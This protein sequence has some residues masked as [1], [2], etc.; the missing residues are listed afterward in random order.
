MTVKAYEAIARALVDSGQQQMFGILGDAN[1]AYCAKFMDLGGHFVGS[2]HEGNALSMADGHT[3]ESDSV[4]VVSVTCGPAV[5]NTI[6]A[7]TEA[8]RVG[9]PILLLTGDIPPIRDF[10]Q[11]IDLPTVAALTGAEFRR[12]LLAEH[13]VDDIAR[14]LNHVAASRVPMILDIPYSLLNQEVD[15]ERPGFKTLEPATPV[16]DADQLDRAVGI[17]A[18]ARRPV[19]L[20]GSGAMRAGARTELIALAEQL[21]APLATTLLAKDLFA[22]EPANIGVCGT[23]SH[24][25]AIE[26]IADADC[27]LVFGASLNPYTAAH[28]D[29]LKDK[30]LVQCDIS[31]T[32]LE[33][34]FPVNAAVVGDAGATARTM[35]EMLVEAG[36]TPTS[37]ATSGLAD[38]LASYDP[39]TEFEASPKD[40]FV[41]MR[42]AMVALNELL[43]PVAPL[44]PTP[45]VSC[46]H[47]GSTCM[48]VP[49]DASTTPS[50]SA[51]SVLVFPPLSALRWRAAPR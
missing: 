22:G 8:V 6:T 10:V 18:S 17:L 44:S 38:R 35:R 32:G 5:T 27:L 12:V 7:L 37:Y 31:P 49:E 14:A 39:S 3:R 21:G 47:R 15:Y 1:M 33:R 2:I 41:D 23:V 20:A 28:G 16:P 50:T 51:R 25:I 9:S 36:I 19:L 11:R 30:A 45:G 29:L 46:R 34:Y 13:L 43:P 40:G 26:T 4:A 42:T 48:W 24:D